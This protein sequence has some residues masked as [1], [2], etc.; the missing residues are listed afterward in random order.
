MKLKATLLSLLLV[1]SQLALAQDKSEDYDPKIGL[2]FSGGG[3]KCLAQIGALK[4]IEEEGIEIDYIAGTSMGAIIGAM[5]S[6]GYSPAQIEK[7]MRGVNW[8]ALLNNEIPR[9][10]LSFFDRKDDS[11]YLLSF[12]IENNRISLPKGLNYA[13]FI[14][15]ELSFITEQSYRYESFSDLPIPFFCVATNLEN[16]QM[17]MFEDGRLLDA[18]RASSAFPSLFTPY[19]LNGKLYVDGGVVNNYP[20]LP[21]KEKGMDYIIGVDVQDFLYSKDDLNSIIRVLEQ[22]SS[23]VNASESENQQRYTDILIRPDIPEAGIT[24]FD[25]FDTIVARGERAAR[26][27]LAELRLLRSKDKPRSKPK[28]NSLAMP[29]EELFVKKIL[30]RGNDFS[31]R[32]YILSKLRIKED[33]VCTR[34]KLDKGMDLLYGSRYY[35]S[36]D[37]TISPADTGFNLN[38]NLRERKSLAQF[39]VGLHYN[40]DFKTALLLNY[41]RRNLL[42]KNSRLSTDLGLG[43]NPRANFSYFVDR[44]FIPTLGL[45]LR[46]N[47][48]EFRSYQNNNPI[49]QRVYFDFSADFFIQSTLYDAYAIGGGLQLEHVD[50]SQDLEILQIEE[51]NKDYINYYGFIDFDS[52]NDHDYPT[53]GFKIYAQGRIIAEQRSFREFLEPSSVITLKYDQVYPIADKLTLIT[54]IYGATTIGPTLDDP[55]KVYLGSLGRSY[56]NYISPFV[57][58]RFMELIGRNA[59]TVRGDLY[60]QFIKN[61]YIILRGNV[62]KLEPTFNGLFG[63]DILLDGYGLTY[64]YDSPVGPLE[65]NMM[66]STNHA[67]IYTYISLGFWF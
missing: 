31:S 55:Y 53:S 65:F 35:E 54:S 14:L 27:K 6:M 62:G 11:K 61:H 10:R 3:A 44:G 23:F 22:T 48:F 50:I 2:V 47:R 19:E 64:S 1:G 56:V 28:A 67:N 36:V 42:F 59:L 58:Y 29:R 57:G 66:G 24:T 15:K 4:V 5:Y 34:E 46:A 41:T 37:F 45:R 39:K 51:T 30:V 20:V 40:D 32:N 7:Y 33:E 18:L 26:A 52:F 43:Q 25:Q 17:E 38:I 13:H 21:L 60:Y 12:P 63:S 9:N 8:D 49:N 16:G